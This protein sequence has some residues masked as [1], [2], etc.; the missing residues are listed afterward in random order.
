M[1]FTITYKS[2]DG[3][4]KAGAHTAARAFGDWTLAGL[5][6]PALGAVI[7][8][9]GFRG[10]ISQSQLRGFAALEDAMGRSTPVAA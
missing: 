4:Q 7:H 5:F 2:K 8:K 10:E 3:I 6:E 9:D 1:P